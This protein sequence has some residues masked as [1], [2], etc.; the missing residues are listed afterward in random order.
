ML[1]A[2][3]VLPCIQLLYN[4]L[5]LCAHVNTYVVEVVKCVKV[6]ALSL[7]ASISEVEMHCKAAPKHL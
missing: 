6:S 4:L 2:C 3:P 7:E 5:F 1:T